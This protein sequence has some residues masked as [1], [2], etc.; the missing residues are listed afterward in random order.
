MFNAQVATLAAGYSV[1]VWG[2]RGH[3]K[4]QAIGAGSWLE[5]CAE[6]MLAVFDAVGVDRPMPCE[7]HDRSPNRILRSSGKP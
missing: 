5:R 2:E 3:G 4:S 7:R 1:L 6:D